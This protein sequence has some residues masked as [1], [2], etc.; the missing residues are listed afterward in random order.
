MDYSPLETVADFIFL[1]FRIIVVFLSYFC[2]SCLF[3]K[4]EKLCFFPWHLISIDESSRDPVTDGQHVRDYIV[5]AQYLWGTGYR[6][7]ADTR[8]CRCS[9]KCKS[10]NHVWLFATSWII[11]YSP[12][13][14][15]G[16]NSGVDSL[17]FLR[18]IFPTQ[19]LN[20]GLL[21]C[22][23]ILYQLSHRGSPRIL[24]WVAYPFCSR[25]SRPRDQTRVS[26]IAGG[27]FTSGA[28]RE[29][30]EGAL[31][32]CIRCQSTVCSVFVSSM[33]TE[34]WPYCALAW[35]EFTNICI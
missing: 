18:G 5:V 7:P 19:G 33:D 26:C 6:T 9:V 2:F 14:S 8:I 30:L 13:N 32:P 11:L 20:L 34:G 17:S 31:V 15:P 10:L 27:F 35:A 21:R 29:A 12:W 1:G 24:E 4:L 28:I 23:C 25:S 3:A 22:R 16:W